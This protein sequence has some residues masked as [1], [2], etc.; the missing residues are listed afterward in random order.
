MKFCSVLVC[1]LIAFF[2]TATFASPPAEETEDMASLFQSIVESKS[3]TEDIQVFRFGV[4]D[5]KGESVTS[6]GKAPLPSTSPQDRMLAKR[7]ALTDA[8]RNLLCLLYEI[9]HGLPE[10]IGSIEIEGEVVDGQVDFQGVSNGVYTVEVTVPLRRFFT[11]S[12]IVRAEV[13]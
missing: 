6:Q 1:L 12:R 9:R 2:S 13:R 10:K 3:A 8:R 5:W 11:E 4:V 7:G